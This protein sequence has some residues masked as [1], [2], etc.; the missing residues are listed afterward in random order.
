[1]LQNEKIICIR[2]STMMAGAEYGLAPFKK[3]PA[4]EY[5]QLVSTNSELVALLNIQGIFAIFHFGDIKDANKQAAELQD[6]LTTYL[7]AAP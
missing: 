3:M 5:L 7:E 1:M 2:E 6:L 4:A